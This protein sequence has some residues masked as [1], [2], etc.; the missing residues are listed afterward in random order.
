MLILVFVFVG[1]VFLSFVFYFLSCL[2][3][4][5]AKGSSN[6]QV[7]KYS[8]VSPLMLMVPWLPGSILASITSKYS[9]EDVDQNRGDAVLLIGVCYTWAY[10]IYS[11]FNMC[12]FY[13]DLYSLLFLCLVW[14]VPVPMESVGVAGKGWS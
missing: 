8:R 9:S 2:L 6:G 5:V 3:V 12:G 14:S 10:W 1:W 13:L 11:S 7:F 4:W